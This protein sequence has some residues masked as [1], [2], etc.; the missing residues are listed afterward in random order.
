M[1]QKEAK[2]LISK[3]E[4]AHKQIVIQEEIEK[5]ATEYDPQ[6]QRN[7]NSAYYAKNKEKIAEKRRENAEKRNESSKEYY[8]INR[9]K[10]KERNKKKKIENGYSWMKLEK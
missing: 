2:L 10:I 1:T 8:R 6:T 5:Q 9:E 4:E 7:L 3:L